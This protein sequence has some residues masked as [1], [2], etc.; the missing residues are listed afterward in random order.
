MILRS[1]LAAGLVAAAFTVQAQETLNNKE[2]VTPRLVH[3]LDK[4]TS[5]VLL[6][7]R[8]AKTARDLG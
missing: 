8:S 3:R 5:G 2:G 7:A 6:L 4:D 1:T